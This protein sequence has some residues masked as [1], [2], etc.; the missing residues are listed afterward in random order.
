MAV[1]PVADYPQ[2]ISAVTNSEKIVYL[3]GAGASMSLGAHELSWTKWL[4]AGKEY[5]MAAEQ[6]ELEQRIGNWTTEELIDAATYLLAGLKAA[7]KY[8]DFMDRTIASVHPV[9]KIFIEAL[10]MIWRAGDLITTTNYD[11]LIEESVENTGISYT[12]PADILSV[13]RG[14]SPNRVI[15][16]HG[17]YDKENGIDDIIADGPQYQSILDNNGAQFI[18]NLLS[19][20]P[21]V[22]VGCGGTVEDPNLAGFLSFAVEKLGATDIP[23]FYLMKK[24]DTAPQLP[25]NAVI[26]YYGEEYA[27]LPEF[28]KGLSMFRL[29]RREGM[30]ALISVNPYQE[31]R[32]LTSAFG[33]MHFANRFSKFTGRK[34]EQDALNRFLEEDNHFLWWAL[35]GEGGM[36]KSRLALE[37]LKKMPSHWFGYFAKKNADAVR[38]FQ[39]FTDTVVIFDYVLGQEQ[40]C[41]EAI[42]SYLEVFNNSPYKLR[43]L[44]LE[45]RKRTTDD[46]WMVRMKRKMPSEIRL[47]FESGSYSGQELYL[48]ALKEEDE[49]LYTEN[50][51]EGYLP[52]LE[53]TEFIKDCN[54]N[55]QKTAEEIQESYHKSV[56]ADC[57]RPLY[58]SI[59]IEVWLSREGKI[60]LNSTEEL[61]SEYLNKEKNRWRL[62]LGQEELVDS[63]LRVL[64]VAC[65][66]G[67]FNLTDRHGDDY[68]SEDCDKMIQYYDSQSAHPGAENLF[69]DLYTR[70]DTQVEAGEEDSIFEML[71]DPDKMEQ[72]GHPEAAEVIRSFDDAERFGYMASYAKLDTNLDELYLWMRIN[73]GI[74]T[75]EEEK[76]VQEIHE[77]ECKRN[78]ALPLNAWIIEPVFPNIIREYIVSYVINERDIERFTRLARANS[79]MG[80][81]HFIVLALEDWPDNRKLQKMAVTPPAEVLNYFEYYVGLLPNLRAVEDLRAVEGVLLQSESVFYKYELEL[82]RRIAITLTERED[83]QRLYE[84]GTNFLTYLENTVGKVTVRNEVTDVLEAYCVGLHNA[85]EVKCYGLFLEKCCEIV[86]GMQEIPELGELCCSNYVR[87][88]HL[89][90]Y[91]DRSANLLPEWTQIE[92][93]LM[94][95]EYPEKMCRISMEAAGEAIRYLTKR[96]DISGLQQLEKLAHTIY[97]KKKI[98]EAAE[99]ECLCIANI[100]AIRKKVEIQSYETIQ[101]Y[102]EAFPQSKSIR[103]SYISVSDAF[104][105]RG[106][107]YR[108]V[109]DTVMRRAKEWAE[110]YREDIEFPEGYFGLLVSRL[111]YAQSHD[112]RNEQRRLFGEM[113]R[114]AESTDYSEYEEENQLQETVRMLQRI[115]GY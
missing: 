90:L 65:A 51:L 5:L 96:S 52:L 102:L 42:E 87:L 73:V 46:D 26:I 49:L 23:Y 93:L 55:R 83:M 16:L 108:K 97:Q 48:E 10:Q 1:F 22:I 100:A 106:A 15:H 95:W 59:Y 80:L 79:V 8:Q 104:Y 58:L 19:T 77:A 36:G 78:A 82:W 54:R 81:S 40:L 109:P 68:L 3:C 32:T 103:M 101:Q 71:Q 64:A 41:A 114:I 88:Q 105:T 74:A 7:G 14:K 110:L 67:S 33:R 86:K 113:K 9:N 25:G 20:Y 115:Y 12:T 98:C 47:E 66:I 69:L 53:K 89:K 94:Q 84:S 70:M 76:R 2:L 92:K 99:A 28:L 17:R 13:V 50:Y 39:P 30:S 43:I 35:L 56:A 57:D 63:Y 11:M 61:L 38:E 111:F 91:E 112:L 37:W 107:D 45:R 34:A 18:Q 6:S 31:R 24:G 60:K 72:N 75:P 44:L 85:E 4:L 29:Q 27:D 62:L 21:I